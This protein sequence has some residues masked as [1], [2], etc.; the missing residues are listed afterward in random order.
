VRHA[1]ENASE[2]GPFAGAVGGCQSGE[3]LAVGLA[4]QVGLAIA[5]NVL[6]DLRAVQRPLLCCP[7]DGQDRRILPL[8]ADGR[9]IE[10]DAPVPKSHKIA[11]PGNPV[12]GADLKEKVTASLGDVGT[13]TEFLFDSKKNLAVV[14]IE[15]EEDVSFEEV[16]RQL[17]DLPLYQVGPIN[18]EKIE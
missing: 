9:T 17:G 4:P 13:V 1:R 18:L 6:V 3:P 8:L 15:T 2:A 5:G 10:D 12:E 7:P 14:T 16:T 11:V